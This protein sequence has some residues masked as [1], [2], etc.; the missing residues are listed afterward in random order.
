[1]S[2]LQPILN[3]KLVLSKQQAE[4]ILSSG[5]INDPEFMHE[6]YN[7]A[8]KGKY[9]MKNKF[10]SAKF[11]ERTRDSVGSFIK[12]LDKK[13]QKQGGNLTEDLIKKTANGNIIK[14]FAFYSIGTIIST[15]TLAILIPKVQY[16]IRKKLTND[17]EFVGIKDF[18]D[19]KA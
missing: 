11:L 19:K 8:T 15:F 9:N 3:N 10:V 2:R 12:Q 18:K 13:L 16:F 4:S 1:M 14:N 6:V 17:T 7:A 5:Y